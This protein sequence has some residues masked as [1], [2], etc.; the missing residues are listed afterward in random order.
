MWN[1]A[2]TAGMPIVYNVHSCLDCMCRHG[3]FVEQ[4]GT[5]KGV[6]ILTVFLKDEETPGGGPARFLIKFDPIKSVM[7]SEKAVLSHRTLFDGLPAAADRDQLERLKAREGTVKP[8]VLDISWEDGEGKTR[9][10]RI[11]VGH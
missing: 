4:K 6:E 5:C 2:Q 8:Y 1:I 3:R 7:P 11:P 10:Q 9:Y